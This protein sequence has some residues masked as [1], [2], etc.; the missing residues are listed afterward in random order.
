MYVL[1]VFCKFFIS[2]L[3]AKEKLSTMTYQPK[4]M[5]V[6]HVLNKFFSSLIMKHLQTAWPCELL[7]LI[8]QRM[9]IIN[10]T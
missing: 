8:Q 10:Y 1:F 7:A 5:L 3:F 2:A 9:P 4:G 6:V